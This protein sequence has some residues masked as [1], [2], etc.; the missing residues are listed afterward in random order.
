MTDRRRVKRLVKIWIA[1]S[2][3]VIVLGYGAFKAKDFVRGPKLAV[4]SPRDGEMLHDS[5][6]E[7]KGTTNN[8][9][10]LT[11]NDNK[12]FTDESGNFT[13][14]ILLSSGYNV[15]TVEAKDRF[16][17]KITKTLQLMYK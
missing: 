7:I 1:L 8:I 6:V 12:I 14:K 11:L 15:M 2:A 13:E 10:F 9:S 4:L 5:L 16:G 17:R 3:I